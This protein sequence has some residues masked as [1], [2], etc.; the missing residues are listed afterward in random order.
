[1]FDMYEASKEFDFFLK[2]VFDQGLIF[3]VCIYLFIY[4]F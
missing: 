1:M 3:N 2:I 4:L